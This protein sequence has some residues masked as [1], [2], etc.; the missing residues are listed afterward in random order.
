MS[1]IPSLA[2][3]VLWRPEQE[4]PRRKFKFGAYIIRPGQP[5]GNAVCRSAEVFEPCLTY[6]VTHFLRS[7]VRPI[8]VE[9][10]NPRQRLLSA[11]REVGSRLVDD[12]GGKSARGLLRCS[13][14]RQLVN[15]H[16]LGARTNKFSCSHRLT[17][18]ARKSWYHA[19]IK[20]N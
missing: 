19:V 13:E 9:L 16:R 14:W 18:D 4:E 20:G 8:S 1:A 5:P 7:R 3:S 10:L 15:S 12:P 2:R 17:H 11:I 6:R